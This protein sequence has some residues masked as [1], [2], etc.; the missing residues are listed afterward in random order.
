MSEYGILKTG[1]NIKRL[2]TILD[3]IHEDLTEGWGVNTRSNPESYLNVM[4]TAFG[5]RIAELWELGAEIYQSQYPSSAENASLDNAAQLG[6]STREEATP[7]RYLIH[8]TGTE[9]TVLPAGTLIASNT[10]PQVRLFLK[11]SHTILRTAFN[12]A[13]LR[14]TAISTG[15]LYTVS[16]NGTA[17][18]VDPDCLEE[19]TEESVL[20]ALAEAITEIGFTVTA[21]LEERLLIIEAEDPMTTNEMVL[22]EN[23]TTETVTGIFTFRTEE[24]G[25]IPLADGV[26][27]NIVSAVS[28]LKSVVNRC[29]YIKGRDRE[30][31]TEFRQSYADKIFIRSSTMLESIR[32]AILTNVQGVESV[33]V[34][35]NP[36]HEWDEYGR[37]PH[38][39][40]V[41][42]D[43]GASDDIA[44][45]ILQAKAGGINTFGNVT[46]VLPGAYDEDITV[47]FNRP[48]KVYTWFRLG[49]TRSK[50]EA[51]PPNYIEILQD[52]VLEYMDGLDAGSD[53]I[54]Q[55]FV[56][57]LYRACTGL[58]YIDIALFTTT[59]S[60]AIPTQYTERS[61]TITARQR[62][63]TIRRMIGVE[64]DA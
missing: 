7:S 14:V 13:V 44:Y 26:I 25:D 18:S 23:L 39:V 1:I 52:I 9:G 35:E 47:R 48:K 17:Y 43:G 24:N 64:I 29:A 31:D 5:D 45:Q 42:V 27:T 22:S 57:T 49:I 16:I 61:A 4:V 50:T 51:L 38:S 58:T 33:A 20:T 59:D 55:E 15:M 40:E 63:Y 2:D 56:S 11:D 54:P 12:S 37:P 36:S 46:V 3:E 28:G 19:V 41:V 8:C 30:T 21:N 32:A 53:V 62:A 60:T 10:N 6:G 34:Y